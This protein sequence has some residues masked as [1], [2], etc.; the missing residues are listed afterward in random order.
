[1]RDEI[2]IKDLLL[3]TFV[4]INQEERE[5]RQDVLINI[6]LYADTRDAGRSDGI[7]D[8]VNYRTITKHIIRMV[9]AS[10]FYLVERL[11]AEIVSLCLADARVTAARVRVEKP[12]ALR[13]ARSVGVEVVRTR[14]ELAAEPSRVFITVGSNIDPVANLRAAIQRLREEQALSVIAISPVYRTAP[15][16]KVDQADF[17]NAA[18]LVNTTLSPEELKGGVLQ[19]IEQALGRVRSVDKNAPRTIDLDISLYNYQI[20]D[21]GSRHI[22]DP[23]IEQHPHLAIPLADLAPYYVHP[24]TGETLEEI[25]GQLPKAGIERQDDVVL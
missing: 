11:A 20:V 18:V 7:D 1:M 21:M 4:G 2:L 9:E 25:A 3:R 14:S 5:K 15:V 22:P 24:E 8:A 16:G 13:F 12:G 23:D 17:L 6:T 10:R 19:P